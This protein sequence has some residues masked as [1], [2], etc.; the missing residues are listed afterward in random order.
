MRPNVPSAQARDMSALTGRVTKANTPDPASPREVIP[1]GSAIGSDSTIAS[2]SGNTSIGGKSGN[3][4]IAGSTSITGNRG[5]SGG[6]LRWRV[7]S[8]L[9][10]ACMCPPRSRIEHVAP[11]A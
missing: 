11:G 7:L 6:V 2:N 8:A 10:S 1:E 9:R 3:T 5:E 4:G